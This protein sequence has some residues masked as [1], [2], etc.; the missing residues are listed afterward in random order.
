MQLLLRLGADELALVADALELSMEE[1]AQVRQVTT[2]KHAYA[3][4]HVINGERGRGTVGPRPPS[5]PSTSSPT[6]TNGR[7]DRGSARGTPRAAAPYRMPTARPVE[8]AGH[9]MS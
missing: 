7:H 6:R 3:Q 5:R 4:A 1:R 8:E 9:G 2:E